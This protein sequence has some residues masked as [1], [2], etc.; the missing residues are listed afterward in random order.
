[1]SYKRARKLAA[2]YTIWWNLFGI[3]Q[4]EC[5]DEG[6]ANKAFQE[7]G[8]LPNIST[9]WIAELSLFLAKTI[10]RNRGKKTSTFY[11]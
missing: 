2:V 3:L 5:T 6:E 7:V 8:L 4:V 11:D 9:H 1:M 10:K